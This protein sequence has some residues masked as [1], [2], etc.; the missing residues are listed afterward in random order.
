M[1]QA[2]RRN[3]LKH[4]GISTAA[5]PFLQN[6]ESISFAKNNSSKKRMVVFFSPNG[7][8]PDEFWPT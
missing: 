7:V 6:L 3:F 2:N 8:I 1:T 4:A 5:L